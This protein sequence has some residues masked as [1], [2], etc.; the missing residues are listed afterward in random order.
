MN[1]IRRSIV[2]HVRLV[3]NL[4]GGTRLGQWLHVTLRRILLGTDAERVCR[5]ADILLRLTAYPERQPILPALPA[6]TGRMRLHW[7]VPDF[8]AGDGGIMNIFRFIHYFEEAGHTN[9]IWVHP[10]LHHD[11]AAA[12]RQTIHT[13]FLPLEA[14]VH[15]LE[16]PAEIEGD[17]V[18]A[19]DRW[20]AYPAAAVERVRRRFY[21][22]QDYEPD[23]Y[24]RGAHAI[25]TENTYR[26]GFDCICNGRW[27]DTLMREDYGLWTCWWQQAYDPAH[28]HTNDRRESEPPSIAFYA[29]FPTP[30]RAVELGLMAFTLLH[31]DWDGD[32]RV[33]FFGTKPFNIDVPYPC[34]HLG[35]LSAAE[36]GELYRE[37]TI[38]MALS[39][40]NYSI[41]CREM[42]ACGL[43]VVDIAVPSVQAVYPEHCLALARPDAAAIA[44]RIRGL[45]EQP[46]ER[47]TLRDTAL[48]YVKEFSWR[49]SAQRVEKEILERLRTPRP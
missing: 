3:R 26:L 7:I 34:R 23:F 4:L 30:R 28:Y 48:A 27:L 41:V 49:D 13:H 42:M 45:L 14:T 31:R 9:T 11:T 19:T 43:P 32:F 17:A 38:G 15:I 33:D 46:A 10:R 22:V 40:T 39:A 25:L 8:N 18:I 21:F 24:P 6:D 36:L 35:V 37:S 47:E 1:R 29:R 5:D 44:Q 12:A 16:D 20:T 2:G